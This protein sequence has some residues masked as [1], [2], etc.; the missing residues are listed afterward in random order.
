VQQPAAV[1]LDLGLPLVH[2]RDVHR[3]LS[4]DPSTSRIPIIIVTGEPPDDFNDREFTC[5]LRKPVDIDALVESVLNCV[6][7]TQSAK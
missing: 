6:R 5:V 3:E 4:A 7:K 1:V 2:G